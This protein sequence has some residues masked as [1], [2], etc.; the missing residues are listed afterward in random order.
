MSR[1]R[2]EDFMHARST[3]L[4]RQHDVDGIVPGKQ[5]PVRC[6]RQMQ[7]QLENATLQGKYL[8]EGYKGTRVSLLQCDSATLFGNGRFMEIT[9]F[10]GEQPFSK[11]WYQSMI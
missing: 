3:V 10:P 5:T 1:P 6:Y 2:D 7:V 4:E 8:D 11:N 9:V